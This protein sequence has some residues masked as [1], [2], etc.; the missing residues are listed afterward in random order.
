MI[1]PRSIFNAALLALFM[2][3]AMPVAGTAQPKQDAKSRV[4]AYYFHGTS[5]CKTCNTI[6]AYTKEALGTFFANAMKDKS[7][8]FMALDIDQEENDHFIKDYELVSSSVVLQVVKNGKKGQWKA[9]PKV[10]ELVHE[11]DKFFQYIQQE[12]NGILKQKS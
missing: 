9:L 12:T 7:L 8:E 6:E 10:W 2:L 11:K 5:R 1:T 3:A 4:I